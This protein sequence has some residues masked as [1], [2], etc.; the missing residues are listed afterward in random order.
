MLFV[1]VAHIYGVISRLLFTVLF[2]VRKLGFSF[3]GISFLVGALF[4]SKTFI[5]R[6]GSEAVEVASIFDLKIK[7]VL[8]FVKKIFYSVRAVDNFNF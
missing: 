2:E 3:D 5:V 8:I 6:F 1:Y 4:E 7:S